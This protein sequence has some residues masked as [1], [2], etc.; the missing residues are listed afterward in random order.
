M[1]PVVV[2]I[3]ER[4][5][6]QFGMDAAISTSEFLQVAGRVGLFTIDGG[7]WQLILRGATGNLLASG[8]EGAGP[9]TEVAPDDSID[10]AFLRPTWQAQVEAARL[11]AGSPRNRLTFGAFGQRLSE[12]NAFVDRSLGL[13]TLF[14]REV[15]DHRS[16]DRLSPGARGR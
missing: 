15:T 11:W 5:P 8:L 4:N 3:Q 7:R 14:T 6:L 10:R 16:V 13:N 2:R 1:T 9:F 12:P